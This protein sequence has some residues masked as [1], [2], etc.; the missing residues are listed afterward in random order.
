MFKE[1]RRFKQAEQKSTLRDR[2]DTGCTGVETVGEGKL[3]D[4]I[5]AMITTGG[6]LI[7]SERIEVEIPVK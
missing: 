1:A 6:T 2:F 4:S 7:N 5:Q 3:P